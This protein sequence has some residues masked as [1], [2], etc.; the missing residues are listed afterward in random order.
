LE[1]FRR[2]RPRE[3]QQLVERGELELHLMAAPAP[4]LVQFWRRFGFIALGIGLLL[5]ALI[6]YAEIFVY[7]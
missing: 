6:L 7:K 4:I 5:I 1:K 2:N 3:Y